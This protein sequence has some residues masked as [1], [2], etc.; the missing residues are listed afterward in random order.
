MDNSYTNHIQPKTTAPGVRKVSNVVNRYGMSRSQIKPVRLYF[1]AAVKPH[2]LPGGCS[3]FI[4]DSKNTVI[5]SGSTIVKQ[6]VPSK[7]RLELEGLLNGLQAAYL[8]KRTSLIVRGCSEFISDYFSNKVELP[9]FSTIYYDHKDLI[10][11]IWKGLAMFDLVEY[12]VITEKKNYFASKLARNVLASYEK[13]FPK[14]EHSE[15]LEDS[16]S[17]DIPSVDNAGS[18]GS[19]KS[20]TWTSLTNLNLKVVESPKKSASNGILSDISQ[21]SKQPFGIMPL[22]ISLE[23][24]PLRV[25]V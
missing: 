15:Y 3:W 17:S 1:S 13:R 22:P 25:M 11:A 14:I 5:C 7:I 16:N 9:Y 21:W 8:K 2:Y 18:V 23:D 10:K 19:P 24:Q 12:E 6:S 4:V 20:I